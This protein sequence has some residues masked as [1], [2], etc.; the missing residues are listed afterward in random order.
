M[1]K[2]D[3]KSIDKCELFRDLEDVCKPDKRMKYFCADE[4]CTNLLSD[5]IKYQ[6]NIISGL[7]L[8]DYVPDEIYIRYD[9][10]KNL[11]LYAWFV[12]RFHNVAELHLYS[13]LEMALRLR[14]GDEAK[15]E[16]EEYVRGKS[17]KHRKKYNPTLHSL[18]CFTVNHGYIVASD[19]EA[20]NVSFGQESG[21]TSSSEQEDRF[22]Q[23]FVGIVP[24]FRNDLGHG[25]ITLH[26]D[27]QR[28]FTMVRDV[29]VKIFNPHPHN[30]I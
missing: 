28:S 2:H 17:G 3:K 8:P 21:G 6:R 30:A 15:S 14:Y 4:F 5:D 24:K 7:V 25:S 23:N 19:F 26:P 1:V 16:H 20:Y 27:I 18:L 9:T 11:F 29:L 22:L 10:A 13:T 12:Y